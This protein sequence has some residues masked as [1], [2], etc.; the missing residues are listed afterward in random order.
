MSILSIPLFITLK[1]RKKVISPSHLLIYST[2]LNR[3]DRETG[4]IRFQKEDSVP[5]FVPIRRIEPCSRERERNFAKGREISSLASVPSSKGTSSEIKPLLSSL[6]LDHRRSDG[7]SDGIR[8]REPF[9]ERFTR[10]REPMNNN[11]AIKLDRSIEETSK[12]ISS[13]SWTIL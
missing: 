6:L 10:K 1:T 11:T 8:S 4:S 13:P 9:S 2:Q 7:G 3:L 12:R 5:F